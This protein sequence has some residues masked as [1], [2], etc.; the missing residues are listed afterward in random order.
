MH[1][2]KMILKVTGKK[3]VLQGGVISP[4]LINRLFGDDENTNK[5]HSP[6][7]KDYVKANYEL[8][9]DLEAL[10]RD[11]VDYGN[12]KEKSERL[13]TKLEPPVESPGTAWSAIL[14]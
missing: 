14:P 8:A 1:L 10:I 5:V 7:F 9:T 2:L 11:F 4:L 13:G 12:T 6:E 3:G